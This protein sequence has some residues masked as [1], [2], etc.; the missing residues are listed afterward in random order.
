MTRILADLSEEDVAWLDAEA[1]EQGKSR[2][3]LLREAVEAFRAGA[4]KDW[5]EA[6]S[7]YWAGRDKD[8]E[9]S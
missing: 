9:A 6:G 5:I 3:Q 8:G 2:A 7:G 4:P 1:A